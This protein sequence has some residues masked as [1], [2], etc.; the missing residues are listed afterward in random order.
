MCLLVDR[1]VYKLAEVVKCRGPV[2][3]GVHSEL[4]VLNREDACTMQ[5]YVD[6]CCASWW[7]WTGL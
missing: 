5:T 7:S 6:F 1:L 4:A 2:R 3:G